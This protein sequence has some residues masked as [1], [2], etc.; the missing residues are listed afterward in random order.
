MKA[1]APT[2]WISALNA[3]GTTVPLTLGSS[4][5]L[6]A[7]VA[8]EY[9]GAGILAG[10]IGLGVL[11]LMT[12]RASRPVFYSARFFEAATLGTIVL[13]LGAM[14][15]GWGI[16][17]TAETR[18][19]LMVGV[20]VIATLVVGMLW[21]IKA[22]RLARFVPSTVHVGFANAITIAILI[23]QSRS[24][25]EQ[26]QG[27][28]AAWLPLIIAFATLVV[29]VAT[30][31][32]RPGW[33][34]SSVGLAAGL[35]I[36]WM[37]DPAH[38]KLPRILNAED[39]TVPLMHVSA[40]AL[41]MPPL[42]MLEATGWLVI[43]GAV[44]GT[45][46]FLNTVVTGQ[47][48]SQTDD[49]EE[50]RPADAR[51]ET[52]GLLIAG[53]L[54][55]A[56]LSGSPTASLA[57]AIHGP[58][59][60]QVVLCFACMTLFLLMTP[61]LWWLPIAA[62]SGV[63]LYDGWTLLNR[64]SLR[65]AWTWIHTRQLSRLDKEDTLL[66]A[67]VM[68]AS[69]V[70]NMLAGLLVGLVLGLLLHAHRSTRQPVR[71]IWTGQQITSN[72]ARSREEM[73][74]LNAHGHD[75][76]VFQLDSQQFFASASQLNRTVREQ[77]DGAFYVILDWSK[78][79]HIDTSVAQVV[80]KLD[81][82]LRR[83]GRLVWHTSATQQAEEVQRTLGQYIQDPQWAYD[84]D[85][86]LEKAENLLLQHY[87]PLLASSYGMPATPSWLTR[88]PSPL[89]ASLDQKLQ[90][91]HFQP[92]DVIVKEGD[93]SDCWWLMVSGRAS[94]YL[95]HG[96]EGEIRIAGISPGTT[97]GEMGFLDGSR[98]SATV[99]AE[100]EVHALRLSR[101]D[102]DELAVE[103]PAIVQHLLTFL[104]TDISA[105]LRFANQKKLTQ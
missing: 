15:P 7:M 75:I 92:G 34:A 90:M 29:A 84:L 72:C 78:V 19:F 77:S 81:Q 76:R 55:S 56:P 69:L 51:R 91:T 57:G 105:R 23:S 63:M 70:I 59:N 25:H 74:L 33:P 43:H 1:L 20:M 66:V 10:L 88:L 67:S 32:W 16:P 86:A 64:P 98:R 93:A 27:S 28:D 38:D 53:L 97:V 13:K 17:N 39:L 46:I 18:L 48:L 94:V 45:L 4:V 40:V 87:N 83:S 73:A 71:N 96:K 44:I 6:Y 49:R 101:A 41:Q 89:R 52:A 12:A 100:L 8:P 54:G 26:A 22:Q 9:L 35:L 31:R 80:G 47:M 58:I 60:A 36:A 79:S 65:L 37:L 3:L 11:H 14:L 62:V 102:Y 61:T 82:H 68:A 103:H 5:L 99:V 42:A 104:T 85:R 24:L 30:R 95:K 50:V 21:G 2:V